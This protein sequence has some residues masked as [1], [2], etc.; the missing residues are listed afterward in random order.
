MR[1]RRPKF[2]W[3]YYEIYC[4]KFRANSHFAGE[5]LRDLGGVKLLFSLEYLLAS[6]GA[7]R[8]PV[9]FSTLGALRRWSRLVL[10]LEYETLRL[11]LR[12]YEGLLRLSPEPDPL[13][14]LCRFPRNPPRSLLP[15]PP[16][17]RPP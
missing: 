16:P 8:R 12:P 17:P 14:L 5:R 1:Y 10:S 2:F 6:L 7:S 15:P 13:K 9:S 3:Y 4:S 11:R